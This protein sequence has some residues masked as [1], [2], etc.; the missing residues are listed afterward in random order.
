MR[1]I[2]VKRLTLFLAMMMLVLTSLPLVAFAGTTST[3]VIS[4]NDISCVNKAFE[5]LSDEYDN[6]KGSV[7]CVSGKLYCMDNEGN[8]NLYHSCYLYTL[9]DCW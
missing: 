4:G 9:L 5:K 6:S 1:N 7:Y 2:W 3:C 8:T